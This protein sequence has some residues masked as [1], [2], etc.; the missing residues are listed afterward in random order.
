MVSPR[1][2]KRDLQGLEGRDYDTPSQDVVE[3][4]LL[5]MGVCGSAALRL[6]KD[7]NLYDITPQGVEIVF[8]HGSGSSGPISGAI[9]VCPKYQQ[10]IVGLLNG[11]PV[12]PRERCPLYKAMVSTVEEAKGMSLP[13]VEVKQSGSSLEAIAGEIDPLLGAS[14]EELMG[15]TETPYSDVVSSMSNFSAPPKKVDG[16]LTSRVAD[17]NPSL[18]KQFSN[19]TE[20]TYNDG[21]LPWMPGSVGR[22][23]EGNPIP[24]SSHFGEHDPL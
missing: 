22:K 12:D 7:P 10:I 3:H 17:L 1:R 23:R 20:G 2:I 19:V 9:G 13:A 11:D 14:V 15:A 21:G 16:R 18:Y 4:Q 24:D 8:S 6:I 5:R